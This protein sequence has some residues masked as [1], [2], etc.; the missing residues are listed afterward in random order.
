MLRSAQLCHAL[1]SYD[2]LSSALLDKKTD[3]T[4]P[5]MP[6]MDVAAAIADKHVRNAAMDSLFVQEKHQ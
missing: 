5:R 3:E 4:P 1:L 6:A 2:P